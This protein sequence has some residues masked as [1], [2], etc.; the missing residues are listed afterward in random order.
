MNTRLNQRYRHANPSGDG[1]TDTE[2]S[3]GCS[4]TTAHEDSQVLPTFLYF[5]ILLHFSLVK[6][7][8]THSLSIKVAL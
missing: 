5:S 1:S 3:Y 8:I 7:D 2:K 6:I 4:R